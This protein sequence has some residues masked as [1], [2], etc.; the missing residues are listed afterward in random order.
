MCVCVRERGGGRGWVEERPWCV[1]GF[2]SS[3]VWG[4]VTRA[5]G[6]GPLGTCD[7]AKGHCETRVWGGCVGMREPLQTWEGRECSPRGKK[8]T[9]EKC[10]ETVKYGRDRLK[11]FLTEHLKSL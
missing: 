1:S 4:F 2:A 11:R 3:G 5:W 9:F 6:G 10:P 8:P 7:D